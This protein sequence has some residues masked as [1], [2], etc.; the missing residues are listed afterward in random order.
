VGV[1]LQWPG[2]NCTNLRLTDGT[3]IQVPAS[4][5]KLQSSDGCLRL[6]RVNVI[7][8]TPAVVEPKQQQNKKEE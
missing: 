8:I 1:K 6:A 4:R 7:R 5:S 3:Q 2:A